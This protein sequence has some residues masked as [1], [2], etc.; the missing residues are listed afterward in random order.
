MESNFTCFIPP[1][2]TL[3]LMYILVIHLGQRRVV[4]LQLSDCYAIFKETEVSFHPLNDRMS[5]YGF[6]SL[7][8]LT[9]SNAH[10]QIPCD[11][12]LSPAHIRVIQTTSPREHRWKV[13]SKHA[14]AVGYVMDIWSMK[15][16]SDL[17]SVLMHSAF[18]LNLTP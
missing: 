15:E 1:G 11:V 18:G 17:A 3:F 6:T 14:D 4:A 13:W 5:L 12:F 9:D 8:A 7:W 10:V 16:I 2:K